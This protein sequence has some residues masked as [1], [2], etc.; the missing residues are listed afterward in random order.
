MAGGSGPGSIVSGPASGSR[1]IVA[2]ATI[3]NNTSHAASTAPATISHG[4]ASAYFSAAPTMGTSV[5]HE[6][7]V[8]QGV[9]L[10][11]MPKGTA[12][13]KGGG[14]AKPSGA[15]RSVIPDGPSP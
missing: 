10:V 1:G 11:E 12:H 5:T 3:V 2:R 6:T 9:K 15:C 8:G 4:I 14:Q 7:E 13:R